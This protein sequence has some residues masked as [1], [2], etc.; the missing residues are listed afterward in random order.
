MVED[1]LTPLLQQDISEF[2]D[3]V[4]YDREEQLYYDAK[5]NDCSSK[6]W[7]CILR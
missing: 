5:Y 7:E 1:T 4:K 3:R 6:P 2:P